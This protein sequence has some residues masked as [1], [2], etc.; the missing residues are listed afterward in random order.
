M[1]F[2]MSLVRH[3]HR[4]PQKPKSAAKTARTSK[5][6]KRNERRAV[7]MEWKQ[8]RVE[9]SPG[10]SWNLT[11]QPHPPLHL[12]QETSLVEFGSPVI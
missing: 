12:A 8:R 3:N 6:S 7:L 11:C 4:A 10:V 1:I 9:A 2:S 5:V